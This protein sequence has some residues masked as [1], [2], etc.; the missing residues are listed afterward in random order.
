MAA[1]PYKVQEGFAIPGAEGVP[2]G[3]GAG[4]LLKVMDGP[5][6]G[7][8]AA[9][10]AHPGQCGPELRLRHLPQDLP[11]QTGGHGFHLSADGCE[12]PSHLAVAAPGVGNAES[13]ARREKPIGVELFDNGSG[14]V[15][16]IRKDDAAHGAGQLV[17]QTAGL[18]EVGI[19]GILADLRQLRRGQTAIVLAVEDRRHPH[20]KGSGAGKPAAP[21]HIA[22]GVGVEAA[23]L[24]SR[25]P[26]ALRDA[27]DEAGRMGT[28]PCLR[29]RLAQINDVQLVEPPGLDPQKA[30]VAG[31]D[32]RYQVQRHGCRQTIT[33]LVVGV[34]AAQLRPARG[35][36]QPHLPP[37]PEVKLKLRQRRAVPLPLAG[38]G[39]R[40]IKRRQRTVPFPCRDLFSELSA[41]RHVSPSCVEKLPGFVNT[42]LIHAAG[43]CNSE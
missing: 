4:V 20:L 19:L 21:Q 28:L 1:L 26:E 34:V 24:L 13:H 23:H 18:A 35:R 8:V 9:A 31:R 15:R 42:I 10:S 2:L 22:D 30:V 40:P 3:K 6:R 14:W 27:P 12:L 32:H 5:Q 16:K 25:C 11:A 39:R 41:C 33:M 38:K 7:A 37:G 36:V 29:R 17:Q 43:F